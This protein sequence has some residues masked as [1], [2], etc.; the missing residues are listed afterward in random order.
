MGPLFMDTC[1]WIP[2]DEVK[3]PKVFR[4]QAAGVADP[5]PATPS[6]LGSICVGI[7]ARALVGLDLE[8]PL[9]SVCWH[10]HF[11]SRR[12]DSPKTPKKNRQQGHYSRCL[13][14]P[15]SVSGMTLAFFFF[16]ATG[17]RYRG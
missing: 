16:R 4:F 14:G 2:L 8:L 1:A 7:W 12:N 10:L 15:G 5:Y 13:C 9:S 17:C 11:K 3:P 6:L